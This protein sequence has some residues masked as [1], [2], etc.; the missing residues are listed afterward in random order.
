MF[1]LVIGADGAWSRVRP[2]LTKASHYFSGVHCITLTIPRIT[3]KYP[4]L[5]KLLGRGSYSAYGER[6]GVMFQRGS[7]D[8]ARIYLML[9]SDSET[10]LKTTCLDTLSP[11]AVKEK[12]LKEPELYGNWGSEL[13]ELIAAGC[14]EAS[15]VDSTL[16]VKP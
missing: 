3:K 5:A 9:T 16:D 7:L 6:K 1:D 13:K 8:S 4:Q 12:L 10:W 15:K 14:E 11:I 2:H